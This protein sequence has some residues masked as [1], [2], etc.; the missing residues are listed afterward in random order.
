MEYD[1]AKGH[2]LLEHAYP[3]DA[4]PVPTVWVD[5]SLVL[6]NTKS[7]SIAPGTWINVIGYV[8]ALPRQTRSK[9]GNLGHNALHTARLQAVLIWDAGAVRLEDY[10]NTLEKQKRVQRGLRSTKS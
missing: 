1:L 6:E 8:Q 4:S 7:T 2:L 5:I 3:K 10:E 9:S